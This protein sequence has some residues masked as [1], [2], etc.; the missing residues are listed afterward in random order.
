MAEKTL[1]VFFVPNNTLRLLK[2]FGKQ[3]LER[4]FGTLKIVEKL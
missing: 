1:Y 3:A 2:S 4:N